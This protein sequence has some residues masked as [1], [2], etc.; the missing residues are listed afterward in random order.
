MGPRRRRSNRRR[1]QDSMGTTV[2]NMDRPVQGDHPRAS[3]RH[4]SRKAPLPLA[5][6]QPAWTVKPCASGCASRPPSTYLESVRILRTCG[7]PLRT[8]LRSSG[9]PADRLSSRTASAQAKTT[10]ARKNLDESCGGSAGYNTFH[11]R[12]GEPTRS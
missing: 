5:Q 8:S 4:H 12:G 2:Q 9:R 1:P 11:Q 10:M 3:A 6:A 7:H